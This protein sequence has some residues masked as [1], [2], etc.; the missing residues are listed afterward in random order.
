MDNDSK[1]LKTKRRP[2]VRKITVVLMITVLIISM[3]SHLLAENK[4]ILTWQ[5][6]SVLLQGSNNVLKDLSEAEQESRKQY[7]E[8]AET[9]KTIDT[10]G[11]T[12]K[13]LDEEIRIAYD[14]ATQMLKTQ[15]KE[16]YPEQMRFYWNMS[17]DTQ[18]RTANSLL[19][20]LRSLYLGL[21]S[22]HSNMKIREKKYEVAESLHI[23]NKLRFEKG[24][25]SE[26][27][28]LESEYG[29]QKAK[30]EL[31]AARRNRENALRNFN[32]LLCQD[33]DTE[34]DDIKPESQFYTSLKDYDY[35]LGRALSYR[36]EIKQAEKQL[37]L[38]EMKKEIIERFPMS[39]NTTSIRKDYNNLLLDIEIQKAKIE[40][41]R[42]DIE[43]DT[44]KA[45]VE[46]VSAVRNMENMK[47]LMEIQKSNIEKTRTMYGKGMISK[48][49]L[50]QAEIAYLEFCSSYDMT[51]FDCNTK[52]MKLIYVSGT[53][54]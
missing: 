47:K 20:S 6:A 43:V 22:A 49:A 27:D 30:A 37:M 5:K 15:Q 25:I 8:A 9:A 34:Y 28:V 31:D 13:I 52:L 24:M 16:L 50:D 36:A 29:L 3:P 39:L 42:L 33:I 17:Q 12:I 14:D 51:L 53:G 4:N 26:T 19:L 7:E 46:A 40:Q 35:Y 1:I 38:L 54:L 2:D 21:Y 32:M 23:Q 48:T 45:Y 18:K 11:E 10:K 41:V 44:E